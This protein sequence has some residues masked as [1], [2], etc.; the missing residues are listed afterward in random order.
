MPV[1]PIECE[2]DGP[3]LV[4]TRGLVIW[5]Q[6]PRPKSMRCDLRTAERAPLSWLTYILSEREH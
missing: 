6:Q 5:L 4:I 3:C 1:E 2:E